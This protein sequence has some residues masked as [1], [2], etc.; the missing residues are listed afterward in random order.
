MDYKTSRG[1]SLCVRNKLELTVKTSLSLQEAVEEI[2][3][4]DRQESPPE[5]LTMDDILLKAQLKVK[6]TDYTLVV[7]RDE[8]WMGALRFY[9]SA[10]K[11]KEKLWQG[12][13]VVFQGEEGLD[14]KALK[15]ELF[16][17]LLKEI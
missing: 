9:T 4:T 13:A 16:E 17:L 5:M 15:T 14:A 6:N 8:L 12:L 11:E 10:L 3:D 7:K 2:C 1:V